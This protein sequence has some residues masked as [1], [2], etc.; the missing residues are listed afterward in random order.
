MGPEGRMV[1]DE[2]IY[3]PATQQGSVSMSVLQGVFTFVSGQ[4]A[5]T[6]PDAMTLDTPV[7]TIGIR[8]TQVGL[9]LRDGENLNVHLMEE[10][11]GFVG[12]V[13]IVNDGGVQ[14][15][16]DANAF[17]SISSFD[18]APSPFSIVAV[19]DIISSYG[20][21]TL[22]YLPTRNSDGERTS[23][24][25]YQN[26]EEVQGE[27][28]DSLNFLN[29]FQTD[30]GGPQQ[31]ETGEIKVTGDLQKLKIIEQAKGNLTDVNKFV[32][33]KE[34]VV[35][36]KKT[37]EVITD[38]RVDE[39]LDEV[40]TEEPLPDDLKALQDAGIL[41]NITLSSDKKTVTAGVPGDFDA[42]GLGYTFVLTGDDGDNLIIGG[43]GDDTLNGAGGDDVLI[44]GEG[45][46]LFIAAPGLGDDTYDGGA[47]ND[48]ITFAASDDDLIINLSDGTAR[49]ARGADGI[50]SDTILNIENVIGGS[51]NDTIIG[52]EY[53]NILRGGAGDDFIDGRGGQDTAVFSGTYGQSTIRI[54]DG[55][56]TVTGPDGV[57]TI[58]NVENFAFA[59][60]PNL[61]VG[62]EDTAMSIDV[63]AHV[64]AS[65]SAASIII[66]GV[67]AGAV[68]SAGTL[69]ENGSWLLDNADL[70]G[71]TITGAA[72]SAADF[73]INIAAYGADY[74][75]AM[76]NAVADYLGDQ[77]NP[78]T[79]Q[80]LQTLED[81]LAGGGSVLELAG[82]IP[83]SYL[84]QPSG[85]GSVGIA[86]IGIVDPFSL[87]MGGVELTAD[88][89]AST[90]TFAGTEDTALPLNI[91]NTL[92]DTDGSEV[93]SV[94]LSGLPTLEVQ[95][96]SYEVPLLDE[97][98]EPLLDEE[99][100]ALT[101]TQT[102]FE[103]VTDINGNTVGAH[104]IYTDASGNDV[105]L[106]ANDTGTYTLT[107]AQL[108]NL[109]LVGSPD[110]SAGFD[111]E[112]SAQVQDG[113]STATVFGTA[114]VVLAAKADVPS[115][116]GG[117]EAGIEDH[118]VNISFD[119]DK[120]D[121]S[122]HIT[123]VTL[124]GI[125]AGSKLSI[126]YTDPDTGETMNIQLPVQNGSAT[127]PIGFLGADMSTDGLTLTPPPHLSGSFNLQLNVTSTEPTN[128]DTAINNFNMPLTLT[129]VADELGVN[130]DNKPVVIEGDVPTAVLEDGAFALDLS[131]LTADR[132][133]SEVASITISGVPAGALLSAGVENE[134][135]TWTLT[136]E[137]ASG[138]T[139]TLGPDSDPDFDLS[140]AV[141]NNILINSLEDG[142]FG[143]NI[144]ALTADT[145]GSEVISITIS[146]VPDGTIMSAGTENSNGSWTLTPEEFST[147]S[148]TPPPNSDENFNLTVTVINVDNNED[149]LTLEAT[150]KVDVEAIADAANLTASNAL[151]LEDTPIPLDIASSLNDTDDSESLSI[152]ISGVPEGA[153]L[154]AG[155]DNGG[156]SWTLTPEQ[157]DGLTITPGLHVSGEF[158]LTV[159]ATTTEAANGN[160]ATVTQEI[161]L[162]I[163]PDPDAPIV[164]VT[165]ITGNE[166]T[167]IPLNIDAALVDQSETLSISIAGVPEGQSSAP[168]PI[169]A[170]VYGMSLP[171][172][173]PT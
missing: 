119:I 144:D 99:G 154:S 102:V 136:P 19:D 85:V 95:E 75:T 84:P 5:K 104:L 3:D 49:D 164:N 63:D 78:L 74:M 34:I 130:I 52:N 83:Q 16:N 47:G 138:L 129:A 163:T 60:N 145:D 115:V 88:G 103:P 140:A 27:N 121:I 36:E 4:V 128:G 158:N 152:T 9:D 139:M 57:D 134:D 43:A 149:T 93:L 151:G 160:K 6:D 143:L 109:R 91:I 26:T 44:G 131:A 159:S 117:A 173:W 97:N 137:E 120:N 72:N 172:I 42:G 13:V 65:G 31:G 141:I 166:D 86:V 8:G 125:P 123:K 133:G 62:L 30:A 35:E 106:P 51:G 126:E 55:V 12:E 32:D 171:L 168:A 124:T 111:L 61:I 24:N 153:V 162:S 82:T 107:A 15:L 127:I 94:T 165:A 118:P 22:R 45:D 112:I 70:E 161:G 50:G 76:T 56:L 114:S 157:L 46:D 92:T 148:I 2:M 167:A 108:N 90:I 100:V 73:S 96:V 29:D 87:T 58:E 169:S 21:Q 25:T 147:L 28:R 146:G 14:V 81:F 116:S 20:E 150:V 23:A 101:E 105:V 7:A 80:P 66:N 68:L 40:I 10:R 37:G 77:L 69:L 11:F 155:I 64:P 122:E 48:T 53:E 41:T 89:S 71:L 156:G 59:D 170:T 39:I 98:G 142:T 33:E 38:K 79:N 135:G 113:E 17:S 18:S 54:V 110:D 1:L 132:E 67:P